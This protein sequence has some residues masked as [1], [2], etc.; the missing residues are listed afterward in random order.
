VRS[1]HE[2]WDGRGYPDGLKGEA[3]PLPARVVFV[4]DAY[5]AMTTTRPYRAAL[6]HEQ[7]VAE[8]VTNA[9]SQFDP[10]VVAAMLR[11]LESGTVEAPSTDP[12]RAMIASA[13]ER[14]Q[15]GAATS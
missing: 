5:N 7:A 10:E 9:G 6:P 4:C 3:I 8:L 2:R 14:D 13:Q 15:L 11:V 12:I 1:C